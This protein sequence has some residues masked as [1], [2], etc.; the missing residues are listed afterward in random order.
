MG[1]TCP[2]TTDSRDPQE[3]PPAPHRSPKVSSKTFSA[4]RSASGPQR[5][6]RWSRQARP[7]GGPVPARAAVVSTSS[8]SGWA[9]PSAGCGGLDKL[10]QRR[11]GPSAGCGGPDGL[12]ERVRGSQRRPAEVSTCRPAAGQR[13]PFL[14]TRPPTSRSQPAG[15]NPIPSH[16]FEPRRG[17][18]PARNQAKATDIDS[19]GEGQTLG[20]SGCRRTQAGAQPARCAGSWRWTWGRAR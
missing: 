10:N 14:R 5:G 8:T 15:G 6:L 17:C 12:D 11:A 13:V 3:N 20:E 1:P 18:Q 16:A 9:G 19:P 7:A 2:S 4:R